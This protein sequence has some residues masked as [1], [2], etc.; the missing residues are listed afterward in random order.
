[1]RRGVAQKNICGISVYS[2]EYTFIALLFQ[3]AASLK[4]GAE[5]NIWTSVG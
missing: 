4:Q 2:K 3:L 5:E 1:M